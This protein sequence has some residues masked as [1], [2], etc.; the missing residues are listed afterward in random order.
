MRLQV[1]SD[2]FV[3]A[4]SFDCA[5]VSVYC[6]WRYSAPT[7][8]STFKMS[9]P[10]LRVSC[11]FFW[12]VSIF[13][14]NNTTPLTPYAYSVSGP[15]HNFRRGRLWWR[16]PRDGRE[17]WGDQDVILFG[18]LYTLFLSF[19]FSFSLLGVLTDQGRGAWNMSDHFVTL[20]FGFMG[21]N[22]AIRGD[23]IAR[24]QLWKMQSF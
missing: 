14:F 5:Q 21:S 20:I 15:W 11:Y 2:A 6:T 4:C 12:L 9:A 16:R 7:E 17:I 19:Y 1:R 3:F 8:S 23:N 13:P 18:L 10:T 24:W 22:D